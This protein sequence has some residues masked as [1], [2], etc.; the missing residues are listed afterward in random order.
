MKNAAVSVIN[1]F[2]LHPKQVHSIVISTL[3]QLLISPPLL[4]QIGMEDCTFQAFLSL[5]LRTQGQESG[6]SRVEGLQLFWNSC[7][8]LKSKGFFSEAHLHLSYAICAK[9]CGVFVCWF[10][11][12]TCNGQD[13]WAAAPNKVILM[14]GVL[15][16]SVRPNYP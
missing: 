8:C 11:R 4:F 13:R 3:Y 5:P 7:R 2:F 12:L 1:P 6:S 10:D 16:K 15:Q 9:A 14:A